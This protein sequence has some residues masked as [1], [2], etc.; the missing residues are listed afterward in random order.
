VNNWARHVATLAITAVAAT[1]GMISYTHIA[2]LTLYLQQS[3]LVAHLMAIPVDGMIVVGSMAL[4]RGGKLGWLGIGPGVA[5]SVFANVES[6]IRHGWLAAVWAGVPALSFFLASFIL[7]RWLSRET[8]KEDESVL[9]F[10]TDVLTAALDAKAVLAEAGRAVR[11][12]EHT[13]AV[14]RCVLEAS[15]P[16]AA[17]SGQPRRVALPPQRGHRGELA[18]VSR[19]AVTSVPVTLPDVPDWLPQVAGNA[20]AAPVPDVVFEAPPVTAPV[21]EAKPRTRGRRVPAGDVPV[22][23]KLEDE[24]RHEIAQGIVPTYREMKD[25]MHVGTDKAKEYFAHYETLLAA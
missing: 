20:P 16:E 8:H 25:R 7:E 11:A 18:V 5:I 9:P 2:W 13:M 12:I 6:G 3:L 15:V 17:E 21:P 22:L 24:F 14:S 19:T 23:Q 10:L 4:L 1:G